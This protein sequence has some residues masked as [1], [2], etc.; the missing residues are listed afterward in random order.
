MNLF[1]RGKIDTWYLSKIGNSSTVKIYLNKM[2]KLAKRQRSED[3]NSQDVVRPSVQ[4]INRD[5][6]LIRAVYKAAASMQKG[7]SIPQFILIGDQGTG[8]S[9]VA[10]RLLRGRFYPSRSKFDGQQMGAAN[11]LCPIAIRTEYEQNE[12]YCIMDAGHGTVSL[13]TLQDLAENVRSKIIEANKAKGRNAKPVMMLDDRLSFTL[14]GPD[15]DDFYLYDLPGSCHDAFGADEFV[16]T[17]VGFVNQNP[18]NIIVFVVGLGGDPNAQLSLSIIDKI[19]IKERII[20]VLTKPDKDSG[21]K[22]E[23]EI[24]QNGF[25]GI[26]KTNIVVLKNSDSI[27]S[28]A[29]SEIL[30]ADGIKEMEWFTARSTF[31]DTYRDCLGITALRKLMEFKLLGAAKRNYPDIMHQIVAELSHLNKKCMEF[32]SRSNITDSNRNYMCMTYIRD[33]VKCISTSINAGPSLSSVS[34]CHMLEDVRKCANELSSVPLGL[35]T[36]DITDILAQSGGV[37]VKIQT[38]DSQVMERILEADGCPL[39]R[40]LEISDK[41][42]RIIADRYKTLIRD[43]KTDETISS[44]FW[45]RLKMATINSINPDRVYDT[46]YAFFDAQKYN[47]EPLTRSNK[48]LFVNESAYEV[49]WRRLKKNAAR[50]VPRYIERQLIHDHVESLE[51][52]L[53]ERKDFC[54]YLSEPPEILIQRNSMMQRQKMLT[55]AKTDL[56]SVGQHLV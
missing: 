3:E 33:F 26:P 36:K 46:L 19:A 16:S 56:E 18:N 27:E 51:R 31:Y 55:I 22:F 9:T 54:D 44:D 12:K 52:E 28:D 48:P 29:V 13:E 43:L 8:K 1:V 17:V 4:V 23:E 39:D 49:F 2:S 10:N 25:A 47:F 14:K 37:N 40:L 45:N 53:S 20:L 30:D 15:L 11:T 50:N 41:W 5:R 38:D 35:S 34:G 24:L 6:K 42:L 21:F 7:C 32:I